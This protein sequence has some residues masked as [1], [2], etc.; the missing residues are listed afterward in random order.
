M[1]RAALY[2]EPSL[3]Y[4]VREKPSSRC[5]GFPLSTTRQ[6]SVRIGAK[7]SVTR[8]VE[9]RGKKVWGMFGCLATQVI[10][11]H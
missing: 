11:G 5:H 9:I 3:R 10:M 8:V 6:A 2:A 7:V 4:T 1:C